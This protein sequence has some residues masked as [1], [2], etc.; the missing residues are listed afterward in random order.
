MLLMVCKFHK[1]SIFLIIFTIFESQ[2]YNIVHLLR[3]RTHKLLFDC[4]PKEDS[5]P[6]HHGKAAEQVPT[7][8]ARL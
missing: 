1:I 4:P 8:P 3:P 7:S 2:G 6:K 5:K